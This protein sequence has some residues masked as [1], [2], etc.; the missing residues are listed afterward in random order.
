MEAKRKRTEPIPPL[1]ATTSSAAAM[2]AVFGSGDLLSEILQ[3]LNSPTCLVRFAVVSKRWLWHASEPSLLRRFLARH[4][5]R[6]LGFYLAM[7]GNPHFRFVPM[8]RPLELAASVRGGSLE[9]GDRFIGEPSDCR[10]GRLV[11]L[12]S[13][14]STYAVCHP[15]HPARE[16]WLHFRF[17]LGFFGYNAEYVLLLVQT[18]IFYMHIC[19]RTVEKVSKLQLQNGLLYGPYPLMTVWPPTFPALTNEH[20]QD[21]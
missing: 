19:S 21:E 3:R 1:A 7:S 20:D 11:A 16:L 17:Y 4:P 12:I 10:N 6:L 15:L 8:P 13:N 5:P 9:L 2:A 18:E 14:P